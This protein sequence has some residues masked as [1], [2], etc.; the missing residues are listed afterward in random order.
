[1]RRTKEP[2][3]E[4]GWRAEPWTGKFP[5]NNNAWKTH[6]DDLIASGECP[7]C[8]HDITVRATS[9]AA[10]TLAQMCESSGKFMA[11][12]NCLVDHPGHPE[13][14][15]RIWGCGRHGLI[16]LPPKPQ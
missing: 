14:P 16:D 9:G 8:G 11:F 5:R 12:C 13:K 15:E 6:G 3:P 7:F 4:K 2:K 1:M 10:V